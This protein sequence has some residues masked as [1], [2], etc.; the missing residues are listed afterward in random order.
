MKLRFRGSDGMRIYVLMRCHELLDARFA[1]DMT[2]GFCY[3]ARGIS[4]FSDN[5]GV[6]GYVR[7]AFSPLLRPFLQLGQTRI[8]SPDLS[9]FSSVKCTVTSDFNEYPCLFSGDEAGHIGFSFN[10]FVS[11]PFSV[12]GVKD[13]IQN[14]GNCDFAESL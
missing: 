11:A 4:W 6:G 7:I 5:R 8:V 10:G 12:D 14:E 2:T 13:G 3:C 9:S 1:N